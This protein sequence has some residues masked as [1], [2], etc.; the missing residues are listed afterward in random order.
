MAIATTD[1]L[2][3]IVSIAWGHAVYS[4]LSALSNITS[5]FN[6]SVTSPPYTNSTTSY[7]SVA[8]WSIGVTKQS[9]TSKLL[10]L[11]FVTAFTTSFQLINFATLVDGTA[12]PTLSYFFNVSND[13]RQIA[14]G[15]VIPNL[16]A[17]PKTLQLQGRLT[18]VSGALTADSN[19]RMTLIVLESP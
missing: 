10:V 1:P 12:Y 5:V 13:H 9:N 8:G 7:T 17:G 18:N 16:A 6:V 4:D 3:G 11:A 14:G 19:D 15:V 2:A